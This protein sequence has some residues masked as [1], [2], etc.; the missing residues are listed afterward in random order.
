ML[1]ARTAAAVGLYLLTTT[2]IAL[3]SLAAAEFTSDVNAAQLAALAPIVTGQIDQSLKADRLPIPA[4]ATPP[5]SDQLAFAYAVGGAIVASELV[6]TDD[7][8]LVAALSARPLPSPAAEPALVDANVPA[9]FAADAPIAFA[10][11]D[12]A[13]GFADPFQ[14]LINPSAKPVAAIA[15]P[16]FSGD[17]DWADNPIPASAR[18]NAETRCMAE[19]IYFEARSEP[20]RGQLAV[21][22]VVVN[23]LKNPTYPSTVCGVVYQNQHMRN[24]CQFSFAC[25][26]YREIIRDRSSW[27]TA[28]ALAQAVLAG[29]SIYLEEI[30]TATHYHATYVRPAWARQMQRMGQIGLH[31]FYRTYGGGWI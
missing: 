14:I 27:S 20:V 9:G 24:A 13:D 11:P 16:D 29:D 17:H 18:S 2:P 1:M 30:G 25:D 22:Q 15:L 12:A 6:P 4:I 31:V 23:R 5:S 10:D 7:D 21:A 19:A 26:G 8:L 28:Q 3:P